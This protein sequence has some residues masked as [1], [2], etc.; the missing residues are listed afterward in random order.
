VLPILLWWLSPLD[1]PIAL[2]MFFNMFESF[3]AVN[4]SYI[5]M[6]PTNPFAAE[7]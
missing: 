1:L 3:I 7:V 2:F 6:G 4:Y 5:A